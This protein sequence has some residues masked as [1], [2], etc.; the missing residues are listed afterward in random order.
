MS[1][2]KFCKFKENKEGLNE[3]EINMI[4]A[5]KVRKAALKKATIMNADGEFDLKRMKQNFFSQFYL[6][7]GLASLRNLKCYNRN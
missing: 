4:E 7:T 1:K 2:L 3:D 6:M 5:T